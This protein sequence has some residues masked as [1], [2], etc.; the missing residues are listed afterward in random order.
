MK[1]TLKVIGYILLVATSL[2]PAEFGEHEFS[3]TSSYDGTNQLACAYIPESYQGKP[4]PLLVVAH[5]LNG[6][7]FT[8]RTSGYYPECE[9][10]GWLLVCPELHGK[11]TEGQTSFAAIGAQHDVLDA[12]AW[13]RKNYNVDQTRVY[14]VGRS[15]GGLLTA[16][17]A[18]KHPH[19][20]AAAVA[21]QPI[22]DLKAW[23]KENPRLAPF[24]E[25]ECGPLT[26]KTEFEYARRSP[27]NYAINFRYV[28][29]TLWHGTEDQVVL[30]AHSLRLYQAI[31]KTWAFQEN[32]FWLAGAGHNAA[33]F[34]AAWVCDRLQYYQN[35]S[36]TKT[37]LKT[38]FFHQLNFVTDEAG[39]FFWL[40]VEPASPGKFARVKSELNGNKIFL[41]TTN[42]ARVDIKTDGL[43]KD[44]KLTSASVITDLP[45]E[46]RL[47]S[48]GN[49]VWTILVKKGKNREFFLPLEN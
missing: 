36:D 26:R 35:T 45:G 47:T 2:Y 28:P 31:K 33:N 3:F 6:N 10:R 39:D 23:V 17:T 13:A 19:I 11:D 42:I 41:E 21:G 1:L 30:P 40:R 44:T 16:V 48:A 37:L 46:L 4:A 38:R 43:P 24:L 14:L 27:I 9:K 49:I 25:R 34:T 20:F 18:A 32:V 7:R 12:I 5:Y 15:M 29:L 22:T 8:A